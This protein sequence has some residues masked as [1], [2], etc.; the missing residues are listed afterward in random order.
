MKYEICLTNKA[1][2]KYQCKIYKI[3]EIIFDIILG[4]AYNIHCNIIHNIT[5]L[6]VHTMKGDNLCLVIM[7]ILQP[8]EEIH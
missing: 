3:Y 5:V 1:K 6:T 2:D 4:V 8:V 7:F